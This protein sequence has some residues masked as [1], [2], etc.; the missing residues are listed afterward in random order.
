LRIPDIALRAQESNPGSRIDIQRRL[1]FYNL[2]NS[3]KSDGH[4][5]R[6][7]IRPETPYAGYANKVLADRIRKQKPE[8]KMHQ[9]VVHIPVCAEN[10]LKRVSERDFRVSVM[11]PDQMKNKKNGKQRIRKVGEPEIT[12]QQQEHGNKNKNEVVFQQPV[13]RIFRIDSRPRPYNDKS[14]NQTK[15]V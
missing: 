14:G 4:V 10:P 6:Q 9:P 1:P 2:V 5:K 11:R 3:G 7:V 13:V 15:F 8:G 12:A